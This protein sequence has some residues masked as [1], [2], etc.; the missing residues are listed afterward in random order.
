MVEPEM[1]PSGETEEGWC[2]KRCRK[3]TTWLW[4]RGRATCQGCKKEK[5]PCD[6][7]TCGHADCDEERGVLVADAQG[8]L[9]PPP[10]KPWPYKSSK[11]CRCCAPKKP[12]G[13]NEKGIVND[14]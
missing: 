8:L 2:H 12:P 11:Q 9:R 7:K 10:G 6:G 13:T 3:K 4:F 1:K 14:A 5:F